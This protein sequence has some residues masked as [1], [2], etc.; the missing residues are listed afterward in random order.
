MKWN[1]AYW[2][3]IK[4]VVN[5][6]RCFEELRGQSILIT[7]ATGMICSVVAEIL[8]YMNNRQPE[9][10]IF[11][12]GRNK[13]KIISRFSPFIEGVHYSF[14][15]FDALESL[16]FDD[17]FDYVIYGAGN[18]NPSYYVNEPVETML[19]NFIGLN[20]ILKYVSKRKCKRVLYI[21]SS[22][23]YGAKEKENLPYSENEYGISDILNVRNCYPST[24]RACETLCVSYYHEYNINTV[25]VRPGHIYGPT[26]SKSDGR[27]SAEFTRNVVEKKQIEL[28]SDGLQLR[29]YCYSLDCASA[30]LFVLLN[31]KTAEAYNISNKN[32]IITIRQLAEEFA[33]YANSEVIYA[34]PSCSEK[35]AFNLMQNSSLVSEKIEKLGWKALFNIKLGVEKTIEYYKLVNE[36]S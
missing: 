9:I 2:Q 25:I 7:G 12:A 29:S 34:N 30:I 36:N 17:T 18:C 35:K 14:V 24:K 5:V 23:V 32:S 20:S 4:N 11:L 19:S 33:K 15:Y 8:L 16:S 10:K 27:V 22:E 21:S 6:F 13:D 28:K 1:K 31:G 3:D 26:I